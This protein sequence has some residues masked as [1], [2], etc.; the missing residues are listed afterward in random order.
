MELKGPPQAP[1]DFD[2][3]RI[4]PQ[5]ENAEKKNTAFLANDY[6]PLKVGAT[7]DPTLFTSKI[8]FT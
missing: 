7:F 1:L 2:T 6:D 5:M 4:S 3:S 8:H